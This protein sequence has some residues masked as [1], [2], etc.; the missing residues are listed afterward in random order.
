MNR[1]K[2]MKVEEKKDGDSNG[3]GIWRCATFKLPL[4]SPTF[5]FLSLPFISP[6]LDSHKTIKP[7]TAQVTAV[8][9]VRKLKVQAYGACRT[10]VF[11]ELYR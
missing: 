5:V 10:H 8:H 4:A 1:R 6:H 9:N 11:I 3:P 7:T 2:L